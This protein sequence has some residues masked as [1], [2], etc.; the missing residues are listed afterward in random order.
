MDSKI[1][2]PN[3]KGKWKLF[4]D[5]VL[6]N[7]DATGAFAVRIEPKNNMTGDSGRA[8]FDQNFEIFE[9]GT[10]GTEISWEK[11]QKIRKLLNFRKANH[12]TAI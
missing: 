7:H 10:N 11:F 9:T 8:P 3:Y 12:S 4:T 6:G 1:S 5:F 2:D